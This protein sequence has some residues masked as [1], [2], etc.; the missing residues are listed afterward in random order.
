MARARI[1]EFESS[2]PSHAVGSPRHKWA[3]SVGKQKVYVC[4]CD[5]GNFGFRMAYCSMTLRTLEGAPTP[6]YPYPGHC[7]LTLEER[8]QRGHAGTYILNVASSDIG[9]R[10]ARD[11]NRNPGYAD[12]GASSILAGQ[13]KL[14]KRL[15]TVLREPCPIAMTCS[16]LPKNEERV[17][18]HCICSWL[19]TNY[20]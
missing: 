9:E 7:P 18:P 11:C 10:P 14:I 4:G 20:I 5:H 8:R 13:R 15:L 3:V 6:G 12:A 17:T 2:H 1:P 16:I 19:R